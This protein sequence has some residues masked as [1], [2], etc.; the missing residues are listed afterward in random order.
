M[1]K[2]SNFIVKKYKF[3]IIFFSILTIISAILFL[4]LEVNFTLSDYM[5]KDT[6]SM[7]S[8]DKMSKEFKEPIPNLRVV[9]K[10]TTVAE[11]LKYKREIEKL[12]DVKTVI[13][14][15][16]LENTSKPLEVINKDI[17]ETFFKDN[18]SLIQVAVKTD[19]AKKSLN[20]IKEI[21]PKDTAYTGELVTEASSQDAVSSE[22]T[23]ITMFSLP[24][25]LIIL[26][27][28]TKSWLDPI[29]LLITIGIAIVI[30]MGT[31]IFLGKISFIT[32]SVSS[33]L[34]LSVSL[35]Y[36]IFLLHEYRHQRQF[37]EDDDIALAKAIKISSSA[38]VSSA[39]TTVFGFI[40]LVAMRFGIGK[41][42][43]LV[44]AKGVFFSLVSVVFLMPA[45]MKITRKWLDKTTHRDFLPKF[46]RVAKLV[47]KSR[48]IIV[49][50]LVL[51]PLFY[52]GQAKNDFTYGMDEFREGSKEQIDKK[53]IENIFGENRQIVILVKR[54]DIGKEKKLIE[55]LKTN[56][57]VRNVQAYT[58][59]VN[60]SIP[61][62]IPPKEEIKTLLSEN[63]SRII[64]NTKS[65]SEGDE[66]F[67]FINYIRNTVSKYYDDYE[68]IG[69][70]VVLEDMSNI[71]KKDNNLVN[72]L[73]I[74]SVALVILFNFKSLSI[75]IILVLAIQISIWINLSIPYFTN[76]KLS[77][78]G[79]LVISSIQ[80]GATV[81][82]AILYTNE[83]MFL[84]QTNNK[85]EAVIKSGEKVYRSIISPA[86]ILMS[87]GIILSII[88]SITLVSELG[89]VLARGALLSLLMVIIVLPIL[90]LFLDK[91]IEK[92]TLLTKF[93][94]EEK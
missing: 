16:R 94:K 25:A 89:T 7:R 62:E 27:F 79:Y 86:L 1:E 35:D 91:I 42:L 83:Y 78:I 37:Y 21:L 60:S 90:L 11:T 30:N 77:F 23:T 57:L 26:L 8:I 15:D 33:I 44:L 61:T 43:G 46:I 13:W 17:R 64:L 20:K 63:Y 10:N 75:P 47:L 38:V 73:A 54:G 31:N 29:I 87:A 6:V 67:K 92:T 4:G 74:V 56:P 66:A 24:V 32:Q 84:R 59:Q 18:N 19:N 65:K 34:Q 69:E 70:P 28:A 14:L 68:L 36:A 12:E 76:T 41:D 58:K 39:L 88:S 71:I 82:Y 48:V 53:Y 52:I 2:I 85:K 72:L 50:V 45:L 55:E 49:I 3:V 40:V 81:D 9:L 5:P 51:A 80:L 22:I 93:K